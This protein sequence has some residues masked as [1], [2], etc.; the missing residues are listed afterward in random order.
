MHVHVWVVGGVMNLWL[1][2]LR[3]LLEDV[4][5][6]ALR[7]AGEVE[8]VR[9]DGQH[10]HCLQHLLQDLATPAQKYLSKAPAQ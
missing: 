10:L 7:G 3:Q 5:K 1:S 2:V 8:V 9:G 4:G 6:G